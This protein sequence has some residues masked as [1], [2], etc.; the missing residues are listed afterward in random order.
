LRERSRKEKKS[1]SSVGD[2][3]REEQEKR[4]GEKEG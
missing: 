2:G 3:I 1:E 4:V